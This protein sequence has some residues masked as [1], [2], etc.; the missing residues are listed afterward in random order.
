MKIHVRLYDC[1][2]GR[3]DGFSWSLTISMPRGSRAAPG[4]ISPVSSSLPE[5]KMSERSRVFRGRHSHLQ[6]VHLRTIRLCDHGVYGHYT[7]SVPLR[8]CRFRGIRYTGRG[9][10][11]LLYALP[12]KR[13]WALSNCNYV[14]FMPFVQFY[15][16]ALT[17]SASDSPSQTPCG[18]PPRYISRFR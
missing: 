13:G 1:R 18:G 2:Q 17:L 11:M 3:D 4:T 12:E 7:G 9:D 14:G 6:T 8:W 10:Q 5:S 16:R 15:I